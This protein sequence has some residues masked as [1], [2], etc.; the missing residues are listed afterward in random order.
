MWRNLLELLFPRACCGCGARPCAGS[1]CT[2]CASLVE[3]APSWRCRICAG[4]APPPA[5]GVRPSGLPLCPSCLRE[6]PPFSEV[7]APFLYG[8]PVGDAI[9]RLK[10]RGRREIAADLGALVATSCRRLLAEAGA[11]APIAL[12]TGRRRERGY[13]QALL[14]ARA[15]ARHAGRPLHPGL[16]RRIRST[17]RQV[18]RDRA[19]RLRNLAGAFEAAPTARGLVVALV[20]DVVTTGATAEAASRAVMDAGAARVVVLAVARVV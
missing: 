9:H 20:D 1:F 17:P 2:A 10:Y 5:P 14:L 12:H 11:V 8:G 13:D 16:L 3:V 7:A 18:G 19:E 4:V 6:P 15:I